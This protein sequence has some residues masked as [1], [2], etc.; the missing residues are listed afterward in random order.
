MTEFEVILHG[1]GTSLKV[2]E[3]VEESGF[4]C[5]MPF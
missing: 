3:E 1:V 4:I 5:F 2:K